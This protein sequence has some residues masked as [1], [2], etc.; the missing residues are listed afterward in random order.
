MKYSVPTNTFF[1]YIIIINFFSVFYQN[2]IFVLIL[3]DKARW[4][5]STNHLL[6]YIMEN[7]RGTGSMN[8]WNP[9]K[10]FNVFVFTFYFEIEENYVYSRLLIFNIFIVESLLW[11]KIYDKSLLTASSYIS[12]NTCFLHVNPLHYFL[13]ISYFFL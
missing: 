11:G 10:Y 8:P 12:Y 2:L 4:Y 7:R 3:I 13:L 6:R 5:K 1:K 9:L